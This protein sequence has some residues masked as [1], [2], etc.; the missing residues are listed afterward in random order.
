MVTYDGIT[1][2]VIVTCLKMEWGYIMCK[3]PNL[4]QSRLAQLVER[5]T[6]NLLM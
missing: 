6:S 5:V 4:N 2:P 1:V 3:Y